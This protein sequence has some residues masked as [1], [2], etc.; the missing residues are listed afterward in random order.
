MVYVTDLLV[1]LLTGHRTNEIELAF[2]PM[3]TPEFNQMEPLAASQLTLIFPFFYMCIYLLPLYYMVTKVAE[4]KESRGREG[5]KMMGLRDETYFIAWFIFLAAI[6]VGMSTLMVLTAS[7]Q[8]FPQSSMLL[9]LLMSIL[10]GMTMYG[11]AFCIVAIF[12]GKKSSAT[13][14]SLLHILSYYFGLVYQGHQTPAFTKL[15]VSLVPNACMSFMIEHLLNCEFQG[16][17]LSMEFAFMK[18]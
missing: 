7:L 8:I 14:A 17:G 13:A 15:V 10:Y 3:K 2:L 16:T 1:M 11:F 4:E 5:M 12:P 18:V 9:I 6:V